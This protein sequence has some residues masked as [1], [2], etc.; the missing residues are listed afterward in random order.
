MHLNDAACYQALATHDPRFDGRFFVG[1][2]STGIYCRPV[3][4][5]KLPSAKNCTFYPNAASAE[6]AGY[7]P[8]LRCRPELAPGRSRVDAESRLAARAASRIEDGAL[9]DKSVAELAADLHTSDR[10]LRRVVTDAFGVSPVEMAQTG[11][12]LLAKRLLTDT[13]LPVTE[14]AFAAGFGS[15]RRFNTLFQERYRLNPTNL[16]KSR[17]GIKAMDVMRYELPYRPPLA[18]QELLAYVTGRAGRGAEAR[19]SDV[20][21]RT[22]RVKDK[23]GV[24]SVSHAMGRDALV[25]ELSPSLAGVMVPV[26]ARV[27]RLFDL[28]VDPV[29]IAERLGDLAADCP[30]LRVPGAFDPFELTVRAILGQQISVKAATTLASRF[31]VAFGTPME[32]A[33]VDLTHLAPTPERVAQETVDSVAA[34]GIVGARAKSILA[35]A[36]AVATGSISFTPGTDISETTEKL[37]TL[38]GIG[39]WTAQYVAMRALGDPDAFP[40]TDLGL[41][42]AL[43]TTNPRNVLALAEKWR[44]WRAYAVMHLWRSLGNPKEVPEIP[45]GGIVTGA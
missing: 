32:T 35:L 40:H 12:L 21:R 39:E 10:H 16:R 6:R 8:C 26:L 15:V 19:D 36:N 2:S 43:G 37:K 1:V 45:T 3:C 4:R 13:D 29:A 30:G 31:T 23:T 7:R 17:E 38:P 24:V 20:Y 41:Y 9:E 34:L 11:R 33:Y 18:W 25:V 14:I 42:N 5:A 27:K 28:D 44:P 22:V